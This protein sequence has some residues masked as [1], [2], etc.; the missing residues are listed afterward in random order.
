MEELTFPEP[1]RDQVIA[2]L[3]D[4]PVF[5]RDL[6]TKRNLMCA[7][8]GRSVLPLGRMAWRG[9]PLCRAVE[10]E[11]TPISQISQIFV[12]PY[13]RAIHQGILRIFCRTLEQDRILVQ[14]KPVSDRAEA[15][16]D[17]YLDL[18]K[19]QR[20]YHDYDRIKNPEL[21]DAGAITI[22]PPRRLDEV[23][24]F[25]TRGQP[26]QIDPTRSLP[27]EQALLLRRIYKIGPKAMTVPF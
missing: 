6:R 15:L 17:G 13:G 11:L 8:C 14:R 20:V 25:R 27:S 22:V 23:L 18:L 4:L 3:N 9:A 21:Y 2:L 26:V 5:G 12:T 10:C 7:V 24:A 1:D 19:W 16:T